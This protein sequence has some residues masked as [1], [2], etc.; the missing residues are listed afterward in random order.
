MKYNLIVHVS[1]AYFKTNST[2]TQEALLEAIQ[3]IEKAG[4]ILVAVDSGFEYWP[5]HSIVNFEMELVN[6]N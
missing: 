6:E 4:G 1:K 3:S 5:Y 2:G